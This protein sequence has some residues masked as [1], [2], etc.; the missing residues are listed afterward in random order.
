ME[1]KREM[2]LLITQ[3]LLSIK[4]LGYTIVRW[5]IINKIIFFLL[6]TEWLFRCQI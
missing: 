2:R 4:V 1:T 3:V 6:I 5:F